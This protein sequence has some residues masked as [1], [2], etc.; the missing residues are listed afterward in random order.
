MG[1]V[2]ILS[3]AKKKEDSDKKKANNMKRLQRIVFIIKWAIKL[4]IIKVTLDYTIEK[5]VWGDA[6]SGEKIQKELSEF[7]HE[8]LSTQVSKEASESVK[9][10]SLD[11]AGQVWNSAV[12]MAVENVKEVDI[13]KM[14]IS[15]KE[16]VASLDQR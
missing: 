9:N 5:G 2:N 14:Y 10:I 3:E 8:A 7:V 4:G 6:K 12:T 16:A 13:N 1:A 15:L 11:G